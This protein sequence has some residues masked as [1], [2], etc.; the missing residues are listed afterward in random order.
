MIKDI[1]DKHLKK[2][3]DSNANELPI[4]IEAEMS[5]I[6]QD[7]DEEWRI[8]F[9]IP[10][11][12]TD[13]EIEEIENRIGYGFPDD[14]KKFLKHK[15]FYELQISEA[16]FCE[17]PVNTWRA[18]L[19][20]MIFEGCKPLVDKG[21]IPFAHW[22][23]WGMLCFDANRNQDDKDYPIVLWDHERENDFEDRY[24][25]FYDLLLKLDERKQD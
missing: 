21:Y 25:N 22:S 7:K 5:D 3:V 19:S 8:W 24:Q 9:P 12:V 10:S 17:H 23:D 1:I 16:S 15:H 2:W 18:S 11:K 20:K 4:Q 14:Y 6:N 13:S